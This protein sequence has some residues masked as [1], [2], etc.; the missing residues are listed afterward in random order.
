MGVAQRLRRRCL[1][2]GVLDLR[3]T[4]RL[5]A[6]R[7]MEVRA[8][9]QAQARRLSTDRLGRH[10]QSPSGK[11]RRRYVGRPAAQGLC[12][13]RRTGEGQGHRR[14]RAERSRLRRHEREDSPV[15]QSEGAGSRLLR[16]PYKEIISS[17]LYNRAKPMFGGDPSQPYPSATWPVPIKHGQDLEKAK[18]L[19]TEAGFPTA[20]RRRCRSISAKPRCASQ[21]RS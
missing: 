17:A 2:G 11:G 12:G 10:A 1:Q 5:H 3:A 4:D 16:H 18:K 21:P 20:S 15:R 7:R 8:I 6:V 19:L 9:A 13:T 14:S